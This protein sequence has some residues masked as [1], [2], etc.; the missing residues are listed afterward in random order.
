MARVQNSM[1]RCT[2]L[3]AVMTAGCFAANPTPVTFH[4][5]VQPILQRSCQSCHRPGEAAPMSFLS[6][7]EVRPWAKAIKAAVV[8]R[9]MPPWPA[10]P[11]FGKFSN[12]RALKASEIRILTEWVDS[13]SPEGSLRDAPPPVRFAEGWNIAQP[14]QVFEMPAAFQVPAN[15]TIDYH[16]VVLPT[17]FTKDTWVQSAEVRPGN[18]Q[19]LHH[20]IAFIRPPGSK[21]LQEAQPGVPFVPARGKRSANDGGMTGVELLVG[22]APGLQEQNFRPGQGRLVPAGSD[23]VFQ[24]HYTTNG[25]A[26]ADQTKVGLVY[27]KEV[28]RQRVV[29]LTATNS[30]FA[31]PAGDAD[32]E[33]KSAFTVGSNTELVWLMP[34]MHLR[35]KDFEYRAVYPTGETEVL[36]R[37]PKYDFNWQLAYETAQPVVLPKGTRIECTAHYDNSANNPANPD[38]SK[39]VRWGDQSWEEMMIGWF[40]V[41]IDSHADPAKLTPIENKPVRSSD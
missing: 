18:R 28:P 25:K 40:G 29:T 9:K 37:V 12:E 26:A 19:V 5:D 32:Y 23:I 2:A 27:C 6:Y 22:Y 15:G 24:L 3:A 41:A 31:I 34:H 39:V 13:G 16:Y 4:K 35:G 17:G 8:E 36:L 7:P 33:V 20:I 30:R 10:D 21:W 11:H 14:D 38:P 1:L